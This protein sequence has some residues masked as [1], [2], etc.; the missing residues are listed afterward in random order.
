MK[1]LLFSILCMICLLVPWQT[2]EAQG[3][4][5][6]ED[7]EGITSLPTGW[8]SAGTVSSTYKWSVYTGTDTRPAY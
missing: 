2:M 7:F 3:G 6:K 4:Q 8:T 1:K 5:V